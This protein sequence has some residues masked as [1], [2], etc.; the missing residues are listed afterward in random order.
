MPRGEIVRPLLAPVT[1]LIE[2]GRQEVRVRPAR[3]ETGSGGPGP[4]GRN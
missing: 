1:G 4:A 3:P 2:G